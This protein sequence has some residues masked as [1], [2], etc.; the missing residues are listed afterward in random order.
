MVRSLNS[1]EF[2]TGDFT[3]GRIAS[4]T[5]RAVGAAL[6]CLLVTS[7]V[8]ERSI[9]AVQPGD[10]NT[11]G[12][13]A[14]ASIELSDDDEG[15]SLVNLTNMIPGRRTSSCVNVT[16]RGTVFPTEL[17]MAVESV[18]ELS[19]Y[20][21][22]SVAEG[23]GGRFGDCGGFVV[24]EEVYRGTLADL[25]TSELI[26]GVL[27]SAEETKGFRFDYELQD[28]ADAI[29]KTASADIIWEVRPS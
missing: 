7:L 12:A 15:R 5:G 3:D 26:I 8:V 10:S 6:A 21:E 17:I 22:V 20:V 2:R 14:A 27:R 28:T 9:A 18:G 29:G 13:F 1:A 19:R 11:A 4:S 24:T 25:A 23:T 16:Y